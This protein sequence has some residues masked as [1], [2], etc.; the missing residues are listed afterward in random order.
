MKQGRIG[1]THS[2]Q[3]VTKGGE[4]QISDNTDNALPENLHQAIYGQSKLKTS[5][6]RQMDPWLNPE[7]QPAKRSILELDAGNRHR[8][9]GGLY[10]DIQRNG[11][12]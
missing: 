9:G 3:P 6:P 10:T 1:R 7:S 4:V 8:T 5:C 2:F 12:L 11:S